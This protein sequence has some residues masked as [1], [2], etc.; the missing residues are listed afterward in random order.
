M[1]DYTD[2]EKIA[3]RRELDR[4]RLQGRK[5]DPTMRCTACGHSCRE[6]YAKQMGYRACPN[7]GSTQ[8]SI[9]T[10]DYNTGIPSNPI[11]S[12][13]EAERTSR[14]QKPLMR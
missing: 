4:K 5:I 6:S 12:V 13:Q 1:A 11:P 14:S 8:V 9:S 7:C 2:E 10:L 3:F